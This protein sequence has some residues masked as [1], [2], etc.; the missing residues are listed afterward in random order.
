MLLGS[1]VAW[2]APVDVCS[3]VCRLA[4]LCGSVPVVLLSRWVF[5]LYLRLMLTFVGTPILVPRVYELNGL[6]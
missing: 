3:R 2:R 6:L 1:A 4:W 5:L